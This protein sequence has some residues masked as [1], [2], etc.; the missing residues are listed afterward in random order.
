MFSGNSPATIPW[1]EY[2]WRHYI[3]HCNQIKE[4]VGSP[5]RAKRFLE[6][7]KIVTKANNLFSSLKNRGVSFKRRI[8]NGSHLRAWIAAINAYEDEFI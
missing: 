3:Y 4:E 6:V 2:S 1:R 8:N 7:N 5:E